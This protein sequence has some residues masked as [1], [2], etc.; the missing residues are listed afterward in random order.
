MND[1][2]APP[3]VGVTVD[4]AVAFGVAATEAGDWTEPNAGVTFGLFIFDAPKTKLPEGVL[5]ADDSTGTG[6]AVEAV[7]AAAVAMP[8]NENVGCVA[9]GVFSVCPDIEFGWAALV[10]WPELN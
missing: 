1:F 6:A 5:G 8:P 3:N 10:L 4:G 7:V 9:A 2:A